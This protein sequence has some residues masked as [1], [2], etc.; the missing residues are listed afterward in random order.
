M[1]TEV[2][3]LQA[4][5]S[6][7][8]THPH[9][10][11]WS[12]QLGGWG[13]LC[14]ITFLSLTVWYGTPNWR[15]I[16]HTFIQAGLG[17]VLTLP[18]RTIYQKIWDSALLKQFIIT[19]ICIILTSAVWTALRMQSFLWLGEEYDIWKDFGGWYFG[20]FMVFL[21]WTALYFGVKFYLLLQDEKLQR[22]LAVQKM[23]D[24]QLKRLSAETGAREAQIKMLRYQLN[25]HFLFNTLNSISAL[26]KLKRSDQA[27]IM[28]T[29][30]GDFLRF[31]LDNDASQKI[32]LAEE[33]KALELYLSI[34][35]IRYGER[36]SVSFD[37]DKTV[38]KAL[39]PSFILQPLLENALKYAVA[40]RV[41]GGEI[42]IKARHIHNGHSQQVSTK[43]GDYADILNQDRLCVSVEDD[44]EIADIT[45]LETLMQNN[46]DDTPPHRGVGLNNIAERLRSHYGT[47]ASLSFERAPL[48]GLSACLTLPYETDKT[49]QN[50]NTSAD[51]PDNFTDAQT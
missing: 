33:V 40:N 38:Q 28:L 12:M 20:S 10:Q 47:A 23:Q 13:G 49:A 24:E 35:K 21:S 42:V 17:M 27:R 6:R 48:G 51:R 41:N 46:Q 9:A 15:H 31:S 43:A 3:S 18:L 34:E 30:L 26:V 11:F 5:F 14:I 45:A 2:S 25:P 39:I 22:S 19:A 7:F 37:L 16:S 50:Q 4:N 32:P 44:G 29:Q 8:E 1:V 36:L